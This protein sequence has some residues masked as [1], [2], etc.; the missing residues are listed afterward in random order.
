MGENQLKQQ[1]FLIVVEYVEEPDDTL[2]TMIFAEFV[3]EKKQM[4][5]NSQELENQ[6]GRK[7]RKY[8]LYIKNLKNKY[9]VI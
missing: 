4:Q 6:V 8:F 1:K 7:D 9:L 5:G 2:V 3:L